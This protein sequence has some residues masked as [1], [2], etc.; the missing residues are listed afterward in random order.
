VGGDPAARRLPPSVPEPLARFLVTCLA[1]CPAR[2][3]DDAWRLHED[4][5]EL[6]RRLVGT[7]R[8]R[9]LATPARA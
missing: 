7:P 3:P 2:R 5:D 1:P 8:Y 9:P 4:L 6:L